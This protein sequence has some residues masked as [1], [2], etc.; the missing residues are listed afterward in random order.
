LWLLAALTVLILSIFKG[1]LAAVADLFAIGYPPS[2]L[3]SV[4]VL[5]LVAIELS[6]AVTISKLTGRNRDLA[7][8]VAILKLLLEQ[9]RSELT[10]QATPEKTWQDEPETQREAVPG[11]IEVRA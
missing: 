8:E 2:L 4:G 9:S 3:L 1:T 7:Q 11:R 6:H 5:F 10:M